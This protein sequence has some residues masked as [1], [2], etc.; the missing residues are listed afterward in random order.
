VRIVWTRY[1]NYG[2]EFMTGRQ[3]RQQCTDCHHILADPLKHSAAAPDTPEISREEATRGSEAERK[4]LAQREREREQRDEHWR[5][6]Y[7]TQT[8]AWAARRA[9][10]MG[11]ASGVCEGCR[12]AA[13]S[14]VHHL[15]YKNAGAEFLW[16]LVAICRDCHE[17]Y[18][19]AT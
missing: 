18:H 9:L 14:E 7:G 8:N 4:Q 2:D 1:S 17:R 16:E 3:L 10:V 19:T 5:A 6:W 13:A 12:K 11:R 15:T